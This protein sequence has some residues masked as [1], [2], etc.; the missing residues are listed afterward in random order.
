MDEGL[1]KIEIR[2]SILSDDMSAMCKESFDELILPYDF[3]QPPK[4]DLQCCQLVDFDLEDIDSSSATECQAEVGL[5]E[6][7]A[8]S[9]CT[10]REFEHCCGEITL[11]EKTWHSILTVRQMHHGSQTCERTF[12]TYI[13][14]YALG[15]TSREDP[16]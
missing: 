1:P 13:L 8:N 6:P 12:F 16:T 14:L 4:I 15:R 11:R 2:V 3:P 7:F 5:F 10:P 9:F